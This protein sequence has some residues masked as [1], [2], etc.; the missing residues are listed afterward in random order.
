MDEFTQ[1][2]IDKLK[3]NHILSKLL[4]PNPLNSPSPNVEVS[5]IIMI[6]TLTSG[7]PIEYIIELKWSAILS[8]NSK[9]Q[10]KIHDKLNISRYYDFPISYK[11]HERLSNCYKNLKYPSIESKIINGYTNNRDLK[12]LHRSIRIS[13]ISISESVLRDMMSY[14]ID[15]KYLT[16]IIFGRRV[17]EVCGYTT[18]TSKKLKTLFKLKTNEELFFFLGYSSR[19]AIKYNL[20]NISLDENKKHRYKNGESHSFM[21]DNKHFNIKIGNSKEHYPF[22]HFQVFHD[23]LYKSQLYKFPIITNGIAILLLLSLT[24]GIRLSLLLKLKWSDFFLINEKESTMTFKKKIKFEGSYLN[25]SEEILNRVQSFFSTSMYFYGID[26][27][28]KKVINPKGLTYETLPSLEYP[29][30]ISNKGN[31]LTQPSLHRELIKALRDLGFQHAD[32]FTTKSTLIMYGRRIIELKGDHKPTIKHLKEHFNF[33]STQDLF[34]FLYINEYK[35]N[36]G[37]QIKGFNTIWEH[38]LYDV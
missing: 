14:T 33:R 10:P 27:E 4:A 20:S 6:I 30:V 13:L 34:N 2:V 29:L 31:Q 19:H 17:F 9:N 26:M 32:K 24:N 16:Q 11:L 5:E 37:V 18:K 7:L 25:I 23:F 21:D 1:K 22:Q 35:G 36:K 12:S 28:K 3:Y 38:V 15:D 8:L